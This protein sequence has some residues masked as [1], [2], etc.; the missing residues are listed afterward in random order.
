MKEP[1]EGKV[2]PLLLNRFYK[3]KV[4]YAVREP[5]GN[6]KGFYVDH[7]TLSIDR[8]GQVSISEFSKIKSKD[9]SNVYIKFHR[10]VLWDNLFETYKEARERVKYL[11]NLYY[12]V[13]DEK[14]FIRPPLLAELRGV[15]LEIQ[16]ALHVVYGEG[17]PVKFVDVNAGGIQVYCNNHL[18]TLEYSC[19]NKIQ[20]LVGFIKDNK[21][22][23]D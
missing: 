20:V 19:N 5:Q 16:N 11:N 9:S 12:N 17:H 23:E 7:G 14:P 6:H 1:F 13:F 22:Q 21:E 3:D 10:G 4:F 18:E 2:N 8:L 15:L